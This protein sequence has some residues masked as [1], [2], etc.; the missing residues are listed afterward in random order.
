M[1]H[2]ASSFHASVG[3]LE[4]IRAAWLSRS[5]IAICSFYSTPKCRISMVKWLLAALLA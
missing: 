4:L 1:G 5:L 2:L 3:G